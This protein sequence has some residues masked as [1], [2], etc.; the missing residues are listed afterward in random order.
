MAMGCFFLR[1]GSVYIQDLAG[2]GKRMPITMASFVICGLGLIG[3]PLT[4]GF[5]SKWYLVLAA[6]ESGMWFIAVLILLSSLL[7][8]IYVWRIVEAAYFQAP[9]AD[10]PEITEAPMTMLVPMWFLT[11]AGVYFGIDATRTVGIAQSAAEFLLK[12]TP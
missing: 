4:V 2:I 12:G 8:V 9:P 6:L 5:I 1:T 3:V 7:A 11:A 10:A